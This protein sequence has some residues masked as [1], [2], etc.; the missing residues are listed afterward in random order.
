MAGESELPTFRFQVFRRIAPGMTSKVAGVVPSSLRRL[1]RPL[2]ICA[3]ISRSRREYDTKTSV[4]PLPALAASDGG[5][6]L[7]LWDVAGNTI[8]AQWAEYAP[9]SHSKDLPQFN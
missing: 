1:R 6:A 7:G 9:D 5:G 3:T 8:L 4:M 2:Q